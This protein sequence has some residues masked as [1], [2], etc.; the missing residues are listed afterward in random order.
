MSV[1]SDLPGG[2]GVAKTR[3][4]HP[5]VEQGQFWRIFNFNWIWVN[6]LTQTS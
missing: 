5:V 2:V 4:G 6:T 1:K 3:C